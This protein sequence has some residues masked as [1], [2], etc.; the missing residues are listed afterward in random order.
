[1]A[2]AIT[3]PPSSRTSHYS[4]YTGT[5]AN[6]FDSCR[7]WI[8]KLRRANNRPFKNHEQRQRLAFLWRIYIDSLQ[9]REAVEQRGLL[10]PYP[11][12]SCDGCKPCRNN[13]SY[14]K[15]KQPRAHEQYIQH[16]AK[17]GIKIL[18]RGKTCKANDTWTFLSKKHPCVDFEVKQAIFRWSRKISTVIELLNFSKNKERY[19]FK[20]CWVTLISYA[21]GKHSF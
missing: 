3:S 9:Q 6:R 5:S 2:S 16:P 8:D 11:K 21:C 1:M 18:H 13:L 10:H 19:T 14:R 12:V 20:V 17:N 15:A 4:W 7:V